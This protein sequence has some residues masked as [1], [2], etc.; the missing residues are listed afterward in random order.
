MD[1]KLA[2]ISRLNRREKQAD[3][4]QE[5]DLAKSTIATLKKIEPAYMGLCLHS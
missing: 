5:Y 1:T 4:A 2:M 3:L